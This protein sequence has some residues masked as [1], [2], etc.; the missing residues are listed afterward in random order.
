[1]YPHEHHAVMCGCV[2]TKHVV[3][4]QSSGCSWHSLLSL[5][6]GV[7]Q[8]QHMPTQEGSM[9]GTGFTWLH[10][11][12]DHWFHNTLL[13]VSNSLPC[14]AWCCGGSSAIS[15][16]YH[17]VR[18]DGDCNCISCHQLPPSTHAQYVADPGHAAVARLLT[19]SLVEHGALHK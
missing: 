14:F 10:R 12:A 4:I 18:V 1:M 11:N 17:P 8:L 2:Y 13:A 15:S 6:V 3:F 9:Q 19:R 16:A 5:G 7:V